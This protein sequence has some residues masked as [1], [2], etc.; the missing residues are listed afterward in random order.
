[1]S[2]PPSPGTSTS[3][4]NPMQVKAMLPRILL[5]TA[6]LLWA[7]SLWRGKLHIGPYGLIHGLTPSFFV[8]MV[9]L[10]I[11]F[12]AALW[13]SDEHT[14]LLGVHLVAFILFVDLTPTIIEA[15]PRFPYVYESYGYA[16]HILRY[17]QLEMGYPYHN[18]PAI[19]L[20]N[21]T[22][23]QVSGIGALSLML[24]SPLAI[25]A[26]GLLVFGMILQ[27]LSRSRAQTWMALW[28][29]VA[30]AAGAPTL[31]PTNLAM[32]LMLSVLGLALMRPLRAGPTVATLVGYQVLFV[33]LLVG[34]ISTHL[35]TSVALVVDLALLYLVAKLTNKKGIGLNST[36]LA[37]VFLAFWMLYV[38]I[39]IT[40]SILPGAVESL[41]RLDAVM[42]QTGAIA[43]GGSPEHTTVFSVRMGYVAALALLA[44]VAF[45]QRLLA[46]REL[47]L[48]WAVPAAWVAGAATPVLLTAYSGEVLGRAYGLAFFPLALLAAM[49]VRGPL[50]RILAALLVIAALLYPVNAWG[51]EQIDNVPS[52][53]IAAADFLHEHLPSDY[54]ILSYPTRIWRYEYRENS[55]T[56]GNLCWI[57]VPSGTPGEQ[58]EWFLRGGVDITRYL[59]EE[60]RHMGQVYNSGSMEIFVQPLDSWF[61]PMGI[62]L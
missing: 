36:T 62:P 48:S 55:C 4:P 34:L 12:V 23:V 58:H 20:L 25:R 40:V 43:V 29:T 27:E 10:N 35:L 31:L 54:Y 22:L 52:S 15:T 51:N 18:W 14:I 42:A 8:A 16:D 28:L 21:A 30:V 45:L 7:I 61:L 53:E 2:D 26:L 11:S 59:R 44:L 56:A 3:L 5:P 1:L 17:G 37:A 41:L 9:L 49:H 38:A 6:I 50:S 39:N 32:V 57:L 33:I 60:R 19:H 13:W 46:E 24:W 47:D